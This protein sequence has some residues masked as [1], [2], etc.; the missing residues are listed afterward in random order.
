MPDI[1]S[2]KRWRGNAF[3]GF[4]A[5]AG[6]AWLLLIVLPLLLIVGLS[7]T[8]W[9][10]S[11]GRPPR[12]AGMHN[13]ARMVHDAAFW[14]S[15]GRTCLLAAESTILQLALG[16]GIAILFNRNWRGMAAIRAL[17]LMPMM[18]APIF[19]GMIWRLMLSDDFGIVKYLLQVIG[20]QDAP[21]WLDDPHIALQTIVLVSAWEWTGF[22]VL[23]VVAALQA[24]PAE[25]YE[26]A[27]LDGC[28]AL[29]AFVSMTLPLLAPSLATIALFRAIDGFKIFDIIYAMT[30]GGPGNSTTTMSYFV[31]QQGIGFFDLA[32]SSTLALTMLVLT[33]LLCLPLLRG[34]RT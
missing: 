33:V 27:G 31:Y 17:F 18:I 7:A 26:A 21:L 5:P 28:G 1:P 13:Y 6:A 3:P 11:S 14:E 19:V 23:F 24:I 4:L 29:R 12:F 10:L 22:V 2:R 34:A 8:D 32:Y 16:I 25:I 15:L 9:N 20:L 30:A